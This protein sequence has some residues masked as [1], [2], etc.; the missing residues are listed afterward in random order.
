MM[1]FSMN[2]APDDDPVEKGVI[3]FDV[4]GKLIYK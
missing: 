3:V 4:F 1:D 2:I